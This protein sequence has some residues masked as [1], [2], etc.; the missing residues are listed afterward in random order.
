MS[1]VSS[2]G[3]SRSKRRCRRA[4]A[5]R[6]ATDRITPDARAGDFAQAMMDLGSAI[7]TVKSRNA[8]SALAVDC[9]ARA[10]G[11]AETLPAKAPKKKR[12]YRHGTV[13]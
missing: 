9:D 3:C 4:A 12:P 1:S 6:A 13:F 10:Q 8:C 2:P 5:I 11:I 7:C